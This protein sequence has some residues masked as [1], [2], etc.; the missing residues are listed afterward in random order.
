MSPAYPEIYLPHALKQVQDALPPVPA[1]PH[2][3]Y[4]PGSPPQQFSIG[5]LTSLGIGTI[6]SSLLTQSFF[7][8]FFGLIVTIAFGAYSFFNFPKRLSG[9]EQELRQY[10]TNRQKFL[11]DRREYDRKVK[12]IQSEEHIKQHRFQGALRGWGGIC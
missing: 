2:E 11:I 8:L 4:K 10:E 6:V 3:P 5:W 9:Y 7:V 1:A 12:L